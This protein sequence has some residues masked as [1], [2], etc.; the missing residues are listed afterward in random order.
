MAIDILRPKPMARAKRVS[1]FHREIKVGLS[2]A[3]VEILFG[4][5]QVLSEGLF[6]DEVFYGSTMVTIDCARACDWVSDPCDATTVRQLGELL[7]SD[8][9]FR[10]RARELGQQEAHRLSLQSAG[11]LGPMQVEMRLRTSG[12]N[13]QVD[14]DVEASPLK[15]SAL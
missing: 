14:V 7:L 15:A 3:A 1:L 2:S 4:Q 13:L 5:A 10:L 11:K 8:D 12:N 6:E 9:R